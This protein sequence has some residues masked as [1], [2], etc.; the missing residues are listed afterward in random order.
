MFF[1]NSFKIVLRNAI[2]SEKVMG[3]LQY[4]SLEHGGAVNYGLNIHVYITQSY[5]KVKAFNLRNSEASSATWRPVLK[6][7]QALEL[8]SK[9]KHLQGGPGPVVVGFFF[10]GVR[11]VLTKGGVRRGRLGSPPA[12]AEAAQCRLCTRGV[13]AHEAFRELS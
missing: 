3:I 6:S 10:L 9:E 13:H 12:S 7:R 2:C 8:C 1:N 4:S 5:E 11:L